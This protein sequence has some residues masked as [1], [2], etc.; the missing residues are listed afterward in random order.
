MFA[1]IVFLC[2]LLFPP[3]GREPTCSSAAAEW[4]QVGKNYKKKKN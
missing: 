3:G 1:I 4:K 2:N